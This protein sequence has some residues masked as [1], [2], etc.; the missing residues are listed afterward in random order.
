MAQDNFKG[1]VIGSIMALL[2]VFAIFSF[3]ISVGNEYGADTSELTTKYYD[4]SGINN[5]LSNVQEEAETLR[6]IASTGGNSGGLFSLAEGFFDGVGAFFSIAFSM[7]DFII[8]LFDFIIVGT[9][10]II[11]ANPVITG[12]VIAIVII[13]TLF[14]IFRFLKQGD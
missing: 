7:F 12:T 4:F 5:S 6:T 10:N 11:F 3:F 8:N 13:V 14:G 1:L 9:M 2:F